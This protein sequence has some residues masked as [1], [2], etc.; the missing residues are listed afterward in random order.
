MSFTPSSNMEVFALVDCNSFYCACERVF[1]PAIRHRPVIVLSNNDGCAVAR[2]DEAKALGIPMGAPYFQIKELCQKNKVAVY[3]S[4][5]TLYGDMSARVMHTLGGFTPVLEVY[6]ID[7]AFLSLR[8]FPEKSLVQYAH[9]I[10][11]TVYQYTGIPVSIGIGSTK[12]LAKVANYMAKSQKQSGGVVDLRDPTV[13]D[14]CL[15]TLPVAKIWGIGPQS[16]AKL[17]RL[18]IDTALQ[19]QQADEALIRKILTVTGHRILRELNGE[20]CLS[21][22]LVEKNKK[23]IISSRSFGVPVFSLSD[24]KE[25]IANHVSSAA[26]KLRRQHLV[27]GSITVFIQTNPYKA[28][29]QYYNSCSMTLAS[30]SS[31]TPSLIDKALRCLEKIYRSGIEYKKA[32]VIFNDLHSNRQVQ[33]NL[34]SAPSTEKKARLMTVIDQINAKKGKGTLTFA[35]CGVRQGWEMHNA[36]KSPGYTSRWD[37]LLEV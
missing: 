8:G 21:L 37:Q 22:E 19:L 26:V 17:A 24:L 11:N 10:K 18:G 1:N 31:D 2:S 20:S 27:V 16:A 30:G 25:A 36:M 23:Q 4:N 35:A 12:V 14:Q 29:T 5:Y 9:R 32:G 7:E 33:M 15:K 28:I 13:R 3:S 34:F 6:S